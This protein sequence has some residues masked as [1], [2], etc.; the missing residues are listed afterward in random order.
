MSR[1]QGFGQAAGDILLPAAR[2][3]AHR[4]PYG[5]SPARS[6]CSGPSTASVRAPRGSGS[7]GPREQHSVAAD[8][9]Y[10]LTLDL[11]PVGPEHPGFVGGVGGFERDRGATAAE[12][13]EGGLLVVDQ[14]HDDVA[15]V[16]VVLLADDHE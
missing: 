14:R 6:D 5:S 2:P 9:A 1:Q 7:V 8:E 15:R 11:D 12:A 3:G 13:L 4:R 16:R 10:K